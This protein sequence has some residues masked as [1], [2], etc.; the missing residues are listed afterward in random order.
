MIFN[1]LAVDASTGRTTK[2]RSLPA[3][4]PERVGQS[5]VLSGSGTV[6]G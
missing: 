1:T 6:A 3:L 4:R 5:N 2:P